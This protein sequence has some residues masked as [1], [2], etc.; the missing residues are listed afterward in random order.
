MFLKSCSNESFEVLED[1]DSLIRFAYRY[2]SS[3][4]KDKTVKAM[5]A[6]ASAGAIATSCQ[7]NDGNVAE[8]ERV[9]ERLRSLVNKTK[10][11][12]HPEFDDHLLQSIE[13]VQSHAT[14]FK[15]ATQLVNN[16]LKLEETGK[17]QTI[18]WFNN[19]VDLL[20]K[21]N[22]ELRLVHEKGSGILHLA[23]SDRGIE[24]ELKLYLKKSGAN[25]LANPQVG[26]ILEPMYIETTVTDPNDFPTP[27]WIARKDGKT[28]KV[29]L[30][31]EFAKLKW[32]LWFQISSNSNPLDSTSKTQQ[33]SK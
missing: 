14:Q 20:R 12:Q 28:S 22:N 21:M 16:N 1:F 11:S 30:G 2:R 25:E 10:E 17:Q 31:S 3:P 33:P 19:N 7:W 27:I 29:L 26:C 18:I 13:A 8:V 6:A 23:F 15:K 5:L 9:L 32:I 24:S 4:V